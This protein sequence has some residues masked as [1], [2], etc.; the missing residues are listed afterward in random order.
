MRNRLSKVGNM[1]VVWVAMIVA[2]MASAAARADAA[3]CRSP[4]SAIVDIEV[5]E[6]P[7]VMQSDLSL[8]DLRAM[9]A[10]LAHPPAHEALGFY[11]GTVGYTIT[12]IG[13]VLEPTTADS[14]SCPSI[15]VKAALVAV[16][17]RI[18]IGTDLSSAPCRLR[19]ATEHY[20]HHAEAA[21]QALH[22]AAEDVSTT[23]KSEIDQTLQSSAKALRAEELVS[24]QEVRKALDQ[25][26]GTLTESLARVQAA[27]DT[28]SEVR[29]LS[30]ACKAT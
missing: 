18:A 8:A 2:I 28:P 3:P 22:Q 19:A 25:A 26:V 20:S 29:K 24:V 11:T 15:E 5:R 1:N 30:T 13:R 6:A 7:I 27:V 12:R 16:E 23:L 14:T 21:S 4:P 9:S 17:R 10:R